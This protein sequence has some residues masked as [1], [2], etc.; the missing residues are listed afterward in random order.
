M[1]YPDPAMNLFDTSKFKIA[2]YLSMRKKLNPCLPLYCILHFKAKS[3][4][5]S[6]Y[7]SLFSLQKLNGH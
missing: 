4:F 2:Y 3:F 7:K 5:C 6:V 1:N